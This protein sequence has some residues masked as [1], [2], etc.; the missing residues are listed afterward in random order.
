MVESKRDQ[1][2]ANVAIYKS[3]GGGWKQNLIPYLK[4]LPIAAFLLFNFLVFSCKLL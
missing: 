3:P 4:R 1:F 2:I